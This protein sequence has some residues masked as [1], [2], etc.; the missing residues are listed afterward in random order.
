MPADE[1]TPGPVDR[2]LDFA[3]APGYT[4]I[5]YAVRKRAFDPLPDASG[6]EI[7]ITGASTGLGLA[8]AKMCAG[9]GASV[10]LVSRDHERGEHAAREVQSVATGG[11]KVTFEQCDMADL[12]AVRRLTTVLESRL[13][14]LDALILNAGVLLHERRITD[15]GIEL[16]WATNVIG[17]RILQHGLEPALA[18]AH[19][20]V[21]VVTSGG[22]YTE[23][24]ALPDGDLEE[25]RYDGPAVYA[26]TKRAQIALTQADGERLAAEGI[27]VH[28]MHP[29]WADTPGVERSL[30]VFRRLTGPL[31]RTA[32]E[33]ADTIAWLALS[34]GPTG[35]TG[36]LWHDRRIRPRTRKPAKPDTPAQR[37]ALV[38]RVD[39]LAGLDRSAGARG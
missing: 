5:G 2:L 12:A 3:V 13:P 38:A 15:D 30:P 1:L 17:P 35:T 32:E 14:R 29:G 6:R 4:R 9:A 37:E 7:V 20:R 10:T 22:A 16:A 28:V 19:G 25:R 24:L 36:L 26:R 23:V 39:E 21:V 8:A 27:G 33:G 18:A 31:L 11:S 34:E